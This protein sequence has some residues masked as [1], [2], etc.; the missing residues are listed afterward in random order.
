MLKQRDQISSSFYQLFSGDIDQTINE[1]ETIAQLTLSLSL[2]SEKIVRKF[3]DVLVNAN[4]VNRKDGLLS[5]SDKRKYEILSKAYY[6]LKNVFEQ[7]KQP[8]L[9]Q[10]DDL[11]QKVAAIEAASAAQTNETIADLQ[12]QITKLNENINNQNKNIEDI[13][14]AW[15]KDHDDLVKL[16]Q[17]SKNEIDKLNKAVEN[18]RLNRL[19]INENQYIQTKPL[20]FKNKGFSK[21]WIILVIIVILIGL[22]RYG[23]LNAIYEWLKNL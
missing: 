20:Q 5:L 9:K 3:I 23:F 16:N 4:V 13:K 21:K 18:N 1:K 8:L 15:N 12:Q 22:W 7:E 11:N 14:T 17:A 10:I 2:P 19:P 6:N